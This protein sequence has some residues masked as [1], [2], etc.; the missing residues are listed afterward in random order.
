M[1][2]S[3]PVA[4]RHCTVTFRSP[5]GVAHSVDV[6]AETLYEA[7]ALGV[8]RLKADGWVDGLGPATRLEIHVRQPATTHVLSIQQL[9]RWV[10]GTTRSP[11]DTL[12]K[13]R[14]QQLLKD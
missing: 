2:R 13:T 10:N 6:E 7:A 3:L 1:L 11:A 5:T 8:S 12:R 9:Q 4:V 14:L